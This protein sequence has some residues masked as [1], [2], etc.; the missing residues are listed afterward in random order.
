[1]DGYDGELWTLPY[2]YNKHKTNRVNMTH[3]KLHKESEN[4]GLFSL[5]GGLM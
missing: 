1:M 2:A 3:K 4:A 5:L